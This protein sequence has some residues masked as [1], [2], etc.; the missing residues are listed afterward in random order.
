MR[1]MQ[2]ARA[3]TRSRRTRWPLLLATALLTALTLAT[4][5]QAATAPPLGAA[6]SFAVLAGST[7]TNTGPSLI[8]GDVGVS[9]GTAVTGL[10]PESVIGI[11]HSA[12]PVA[13]QAKTDLTNAYNNAAGQSPA[14]IATELG[15]Q[16][17]VSGVYNSAS[18]TFEL[19]SGILTLD[20]G[21]TSNA[22][23]IFQMQETLTTAAGGSILFINGAS[24]CNVYWQVGSSATIGADSAFAGNI[25][26]SASITMVTGAS[27]IGRALAQTGAVTLDTNVIDA[28]QCAPPSLA[29]IVR[30]FTATASTGSV[31]LKWRT[32]S[33]LEML[34]YNVYGKVHGKRVKL[35]RKLIAAKS[36]SGASYAFRHRAPTGHKAPA[37][38]WLQIVNLDGSRT[39]HGTATT[40]RR[41]NS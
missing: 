22:V 41:I 37:R 17:L 30:S 16:N 40:V 13:D 31:M 29:V 9:P 10:A 8:S 4:S 33:E 19:T 7:V 3:P 12:D 1:F 39:W 36:T 6:A 5:S 24:A 28:S 15:G 34:G 35:N 11:I 21:G 20:G 32:A 26:A 23:F 38:F 14:M 2:G 25:L 27:L 18:G